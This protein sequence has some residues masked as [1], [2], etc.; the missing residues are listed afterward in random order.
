MI[1]SIK[2]MSKRKKIWLTVLVA[3]IILLVVMAIFNN[4]SE[5]T[6]VIPTS[7]AV[8][9]AVAPAAL[10]DVAQIN[11]YKA[12]L[13]P[14]EEAIV[15]SKI[16]GQ[17]VEIL[18]EN[19][20]QVAKGQALVA[21]DSED[22]KNQLRT[23]QISLENLKN[24]LAFAQSEY[25]KTKTL[26]EAGASPKADLDN[27]EQTLKAAK[28]SVDLQKVTIDEINNSLANSVI[29]APIGGEVSDKDIS[30]GQFVSPGS[31]LAKVKNNTAIK[32]V[33]QLKAEDLGKVKVGQTVALKL[34]ES[35]TVSYKGIVKKIADSANSS[36]RS[37]DCQ[38]LVDN[39]SGSLHSGVFGYIQ[40][41][42]AT[43][44]QIL[45]IPLAALGGSEN[46]YYVFTI[47]NGTAKKTTV[48]IGEIQSD[49][50]E[51]T[52][53]LSAG[54]KVIVTNLNSLQNGDKVTVSGE[55]N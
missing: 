31:V 52:S 10:S 50:V 23:A 9:V 35:D 34:S 28:N 3:F 30:V 49:K 16:S 29:Y 46:D 33:I 53:G 27:A 47:N 24:T 36:T 21:L 43:K 32:A 7:N 4:R 8:T 22:L 11:T 20:D 44:K 41:A 45:A 15:S 40:V 6:A 13:E 42:N 51:I 18:F 39:Q 5:P 17:V 12:D 25:D 14:Q 38:I 55:G 1:Q 37:F 48:E 54:E 26:Y 19:G 2:K